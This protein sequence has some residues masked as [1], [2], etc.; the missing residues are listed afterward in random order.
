MLTVVAAHRVVNKE[1]QRNWEISGHCMALAM[2]IKAPW[3]SLMTSVLQLCFGTEAATCTLAAA[4]G[5]ADHSTLL[6]GVA[7]QEGTPPGT[8]VQW[9]LVLQGTQGL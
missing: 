9:C 5:T 1:I 3:V 4:V 8:A 7:V 2:R 6:V